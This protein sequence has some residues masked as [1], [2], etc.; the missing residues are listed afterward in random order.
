[1]EEPTREE[2]LSACRTLVKESLGDWIYDVRDRRDRDDG[3]VG[4]SWDHPSVVAFG[5]AC[6]IIERF[7]EATVQQQPGDAAPADEGGSG[8]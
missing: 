2:L 8:A 7:V 6:R 4:D 1:M 5:K 3:F